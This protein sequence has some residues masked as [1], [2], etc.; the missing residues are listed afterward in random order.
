MWRWGYVLVVLVLVCCFTL[1]NYD[2][3]RERVSLYDS[4]ASYYGTCIA[5]IS[6]CRPILEVSPL[7]WV[8]IHSVSI[9]TTITKDVLTWKMCVLTLLM[10]VGAMDISIFTKRAL[11]K[12]WET[13][14]DARLHKLYGGRRRRGG[15]GTS[16]L[17]LKPT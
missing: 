4:C 15:G 14:R 17:F 6:Q 9:P 11:E 1:E 3:Y 7:Q 2:L 13:E 12:R 8:I 10:V 16:N 5:F